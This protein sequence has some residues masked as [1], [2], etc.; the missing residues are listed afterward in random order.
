MTIDGFLTCLTLIAAL[1]ALASPI[2]RYRLQLLGWRLWLPSLMALLAV[3]YLELFEVIGTPCSSE[4]CQRLVLDPPRSPDPK[5]IAFIV[6]LLWLSY[7]AFIA[8]RPVVKA[9]KLPVLG[10]LADRL[11][12]ER[13]YGE[14]IAV[15]QP[16][17]STI[18]K[19]ARRE[20]WLQKFLDQVR[21]HGNKNS[22][23]ELINPPPEKPL[24]RWDRIK[25]KAHS[26]MLY[27]LKPLAMLFP[28]VDARE[29]AASRILRIL[30]T[31]EKLVEYLS[32]ERPL[33]AL[34]IMLK[35]HSYD[36]DFSDRAFHYMI[37]DRGG[38]LPRE[39]ILNQN[40]SRC[41]YEIDPHNEI[42]Y[43]LLSD[44][45]IAE[46]LEV[47]RPIGNYPLELIEENSDGYRDV[48]SASKP[49]KDESIFSDPSFV[50]IRFFDIMIRSSMRDSIEWHMWLFYMNLLV[51]KLV[52]YMSIK[53]PDYD[54]EKEFP[55]FAHYLIYEVFSSYGSWLQAIDCC[56]EDSP[57]VRIQS[58]EPRHD[59]GSIIKST[60]LSIGQSLGHLVQS[61]NVT[62]DFVTYILEIVMRDLK[63]LAA[64]PGGG[65]LVDALTRSIIA[66]GAYGEK[67][68]YGER[69]KR[70]FGQ[71]DLMIRFD[72][73][74]FGAALEA[75]YP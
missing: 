31:N 69:L 7:V 53:H 14:L 62:D 13:R 8:R 19:A 61:A 65:V 73:D 67:P 16:H 71:M 12:I 48:I 64:K 40:T 43:A 17:I 54:A 3:V 32:R 29:S 72:S 56:P 10:R 75:A 6:T 20:L 46:K 25:R 22:W 1:Y 2:A 39:I 35:R 68:E 59:N 30:Y 63:G 5:Q 23:L 21:A 33:V 51:D 50:A 24:R 55:N 4:W 70:C 44:A 42:I 36:Y 60:M 27:A 28:K 18:I 38:Q 41:F 58:V 26:G 52:E 47:Y 74:V 66:R 57:A 11:E 45:N 49:R 34:D 37:S 15:I 9:S